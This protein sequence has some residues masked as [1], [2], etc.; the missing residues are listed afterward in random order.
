MSD[1]TSPCCFVHHSTF[2]SEIEDFISKHCSGPNN[3]E[4]AISNIQRLL[5]KHFY[6]ND[7]KFS[8][9]HL[10]RAQGFDGFSVFW[11]KMVIPDCGLSRIQLP[12]AY[13]LKINDHVCFLCL[14][15]HLQ[16]YKDSKLRK[17]A[18]E[19]LDA[20]LEVLKTH[21]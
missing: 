10:G 5:I 1:C 14:D 19:R 17:V 21:Q 2:I 18:K 15:S 7:L 16:N 12:K 6:Q 13:F 11:L 8:G 20:M 3:S 9:K 4:E